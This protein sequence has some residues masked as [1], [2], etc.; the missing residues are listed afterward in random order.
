MLD[1]CLILRHIHVH[2][3]TE[4]KHCSSMSVKHLL[5][6]SAGKLSSNHLP[7]VLG[8]KKKKINEMI[9]GHSPVLGKVCQRSFSKIFKKGGGGPN[10]SRLLPNPPPCR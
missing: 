3:K 1:S 7:L 10:G 2:L 4:F 6:H 5:V 8:K 9:C